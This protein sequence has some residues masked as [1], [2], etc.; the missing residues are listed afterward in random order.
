[1][2]VAI[3]G[4]KS[5][6]MTIREAEPSGQEYQTRMCSARFSWPSAKTANIWLESSLQIS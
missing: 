6:I 5:A 4:T 2:Q 1:M 3:E